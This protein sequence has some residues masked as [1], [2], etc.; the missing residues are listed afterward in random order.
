MTMKVLTPIV[1]ISYLAFIFAPPTRL[2]YAPYIILALLGASSF[3]LVPI[4]LEYLA[5]V[6][7]PV[8]PEVSSVVCWAGGQLLGAVFLIIMG[9]L[10]DDEGTEMK[11]YP[12]G[13][14]QR[15]LIFEG[16]IACLVAVLPMFLGARWLGLDGE[17][18]RRFAVDEGEGEPRLGARRTPASSRA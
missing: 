14:M 1:G 4:A 16:C 7:Y 5:E 17:A 10:K 11:N 2:V 15:A 9:L 3:A 8:S 6:T 13:N 18:R 12:P